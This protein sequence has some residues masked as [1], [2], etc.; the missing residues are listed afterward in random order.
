[1]PMYHVYKRLSVTTNT[2]C[3]L[4]NIYSRDMVEEERGRYAFAMAHLGIVYVA[5]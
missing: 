1:M 4:Y 5:V 3:L 2:R